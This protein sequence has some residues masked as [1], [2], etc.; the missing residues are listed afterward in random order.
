MLPW[1]PFW[2]GR[3]GREPRVRTALGTLQ[4][5][6][7]LDQS[8][9]CWVGGT[10][11]GPRPEPGTRSARR[12]SL[13][14]RPPAP[15]CRPLSAGEESAV[16]VP[17]PAPDPLQPARPVQAVRQRHV[18]Q[19]VHARRGV[20][21]PAPR[22]GELPLRGH[23]LASRL[24]PRPPEAARRCLRRLWLP[25]IGRAPRAGRPQACGGGDGQGQAGQGVVTTKV[26]CLWD[27][28]GTFHINRKSESGRER[29]KPRSFPRPGPDPSSGG[30]RREK[31]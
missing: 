8:P 14:A 23:G 22:G 3:L 13:A 28:K 19:R 9:A 29:R 24:R 30:R 18:G 27:T 26:R 1:P 31:G 6:R 2:G 15:H 7:W 21:G 12:R 20:H 11:A 4:V 10:L 25:Q 16:P 5:L 17:P